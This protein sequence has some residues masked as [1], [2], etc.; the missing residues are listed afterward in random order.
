MDDG[1]PTAPRVVAN[2]GARHQVAG[3]L[4]LL[5]DEVVESQ[6]AGRVSNGAVVDAGPNHHISRVP[7]FIFAPALVDTGAH[8]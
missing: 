1:A 3:H 5:F 7:D 8:F 4:V 2:V 6:A